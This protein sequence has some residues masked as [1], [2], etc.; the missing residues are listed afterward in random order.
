MKL[1]SIL[2]LSGVAYAQPAFEVASL[3][4]ANPGNNGVRGGCHGIDSVYTGANERASAPPLGRCVITDGRLSHMLGIAFRI[5]SMLYI[6][7]GPEWLMSGDSR[8][9]VDAKAEDP[10]KAT[11]EQLLQMLQALLIERFNLKFHREIKDMPG[12][13]LVVAKNGPKLQASKGE[14]SGFS[15]GA[16]GKPNPAGPAC[17]TAQKWTPSMLA[18]LLTQMGKG[19][20]IDKTGLTGEYDFKLCWNEMEGPSLFSALQEQLGLKFEAQKVPV[21]FFI[22]DS[23]QKPTEN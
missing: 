11:E 14:D 3:K 12:Y 23:A 21:S 16:E 1:L 13:T 15:W 8:Y 6:K 17:L 20:A 9:T 22:V 5:G 19:P 18:G 10:T 7:G 2:V 4:P